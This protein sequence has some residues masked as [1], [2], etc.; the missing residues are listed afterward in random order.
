MIEITHM[1]GYRRGYFIHGDSKVSLPCHARMERDTIHIGDITASKPLS[2]PLRDHVR[3]ASDMGATTYLR[4][5]RG[6]PPEVARRIQKKNASLGGEGGV[7]PVYLSGHSEYDDPFVSSLPPSDV[8]LFPAASER[9]LLSAFFS[10]RSAH[11][12]ALCYV[13]CTPEEI[14]VLASAGFDLFPESDRHQEAL[15]AFLD[16][17]TPQY[18]EMASCASLRA[19][20][21]LNLLY[22]DFFSSWE[23]YVATPQERQLCIS[24]DAFWRPSIVRWEHDVTA[25][26]TPPSSIVVLLPCSARKPYSTSQ[27]HRRFIA[28]MKSA[29]G[30]RPYASL[31]QHIVTSPYG[32]VPRELETLIDYDIVVTG[33]WTHEEVARARTMLCSLLDKVPEPI[34]IAHLPENECGVVEGL[35]VRTIVTS[36]GHPLSEASM[37]R[38]REALMEV[39]DQIPPPVETYPKVR[40]LSRFLYGTDILPPD[41]VIRG[42]GQLQ[43]YRGKTAVASIGAVVRPLTSAVTVQRSWVHVD[44]EVTGDV[45]CKGIIDADPSIRPGDE[46]VVERNGRAVA[47]GTAI[48]PGTLMTR[49]QRGKAVKVRKRLKA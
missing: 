49:M 7:T 16:N 2:Y 23:Q 26:Y 11:P 14:P 8:F 38:L 45:F 44:F 48:L 10:V 27:S 47:T 22:L 4:V 33:T 29:L 41:I 21:L 37:T 20:T 30:K 35:P 43:A 19:K 9:S 39:K 40:A 28:L 42:R 24:R 46:V 32:I 34:V 6:T 25:R 18:V 5:V 31:T 15:A 13:E 17:P 1:D 3:K 36:D 12:G